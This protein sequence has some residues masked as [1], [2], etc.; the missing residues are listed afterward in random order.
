VVVVR[1]AGST[2]SGKVTVKVGKKK[3]TGSL[4]NGKA[5]VKLPRL[6]KGRTKVTVR[7]SGDAGTRSASR[8][9]RIRA[10]AP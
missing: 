4:R 8:T 5:T 10:V 9:V 6:A 7:Y 1:S 2:P 3:L